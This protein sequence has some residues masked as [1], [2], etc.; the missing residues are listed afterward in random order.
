MKKLIYLIPIILKLLS[1]C[2]NTSIKSD[3]EKQGINSKVRVIVDSVFY[4]QEKFGEPKKTSL[5]YIS[6]GEYN[7]DGFVSKVTLLDHYEDL[8]TKFI[9]N[10]LEDNKLSEWKGYDSNGDPLNVVNLKYDKSNMTMTESFFDHKDSLTQ[11]TEHQCDRY[12]NPIESRMYR[13]GKIE[14]TKLE[15]DKKSRV[16][17]R[18][19]F[20]HTGKVDI[21]FQ[22]SYSN[23][24][25]YVVE[26]QYDS[27]MEL[28]RADSTSII[29]NKDR[30]IKSWVKYSDGQLQNIGTTKID[31][32]Q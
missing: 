17:K 21:I 4:A 9:A 2:S 32:Y 25:D 13:D 30:T 26:K 19:D 23:N 15:Y 7:E 16:V 5:E 6:I 31:Y 20:D 27:N 18:T 28:L 24:G 3:L 10:R 8:D 12:W 1:S 29:L 14:V 22:I 11:K